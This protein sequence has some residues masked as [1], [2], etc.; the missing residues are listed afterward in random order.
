MAESRR[1]SSI[2]RSMTVV[3]CAAPLA[4]LTAVAGASPAG[5]AVASR[6]PATTI[7]Y[8]STSTTTISLATPAGTAAGDLV[9]ATI[10]IGATGATVQPTITPPAG[11]TL[12]NRTNHANTDGL[13]VY[14][15][16][17]ATGESSF[18]FTTSVPV[19]GVALL[20]SWVG[21]DLTN[22]IDGAAGLDSV[23][24]TGAVVAPSVTTTAANTVLVANYYGY[25][26]GAAGTSWTA[27]SGLT[28]V[29]TASNGG[30][31]SGS[32]HF[33]S[34]AVAGSTGTK[35]ATASTTQNFADGI[36][37]ALRAATATTNP[38]LISAIAASAIA[39]SG[40]T[41]SW[42]TDQDA[43]TQVEYGLTTS[44]G[45]LTN[46]NPSLVTTHVQGLTGLLA[47][48]LYHYRVKSRNARGQLGTSS[49]RTFATTALPAG[50]VPVIVDTDLFSDADDVGTL[51][52]AFGLQL[53]GEAQVI[54]IGV[55]TR[56]DRPTVASASWKCA[57]AIAQ[58][59]GFGNVPIGT[60]LPNDGTAVN[61]AEFAT[62]CAA[63]ALNPPVAPVSAVITFRQALVNQPNGSVVMVEAGYQENLAALLASPADGISALTGVALVAQKVKTLVVMG[64]GY[65]S[66]AG[67]NNFSGNAAAAQTVASNW[68]TKVVY[69]GFEIGDIVFTGQTISATHPTTSP[70][71]A[72]YEAFVGPNNYIP[73]YDLTAVYHAIRPTDNSLVQVGP[74]TNSIA[75]PSGANTFATGAGNQFY[76]S[77]PNAPAVAAAIEALLA[78]LPASTGPNDSFASNSIDP[79][80]WASS[81]N[82]STIQAANQELQISHPAGGWTSATLRSAAPFNQVGRSVQVQVLRP[83]NNSVGGATFGETTV[84]LRADAT[85]EIQFLIAGGALTAWVDTGAGLTNLTPSYPAYNVTAM[86]WLRFRE[87]AG[88]LYWEYASG[89]VAAGPWTTFFSQPNPVPL[90]AVTLELEAGS[91]IAATDTARFDNIATV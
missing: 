65:P 9:L 58:W 85:R 61:T 87:S 7:S 50:P 17:F 42:T 48:T 86:Q 14:R 46:L 37:I 79:A 43:D 13:A 15:H 4:I 24:T 44:Y 47:S 70:V 81:L 18:T 26:G 22:P 38:P 49:D 69:S 53:K 28:R 52:T 21:V 41:A 56:S 55:N 76:L 51:A 2:W 10:G 20:S 39:P 30:S 59:Y 27:P 71:R 6:G 83:A 88:I 8:A 34:Q 36:L 29:G 67:E 35:S 90:S 73:S 45:S 80:Q 66:R 64:G 68:P 32:V 77:M 84:R 3:A 74:G 33:G 12:V 1:I 75:V 82:G 78:T 57:A 72:A 23:P 19:G 11:W 62:P 40:A 5:A 91:N 60:D 89:A 25:R 16:P 54:A 31:R 63:K